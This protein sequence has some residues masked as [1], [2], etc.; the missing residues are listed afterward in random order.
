MKFE[1]PMR[2]SDSRKWKL[3]SFT[4]IIKQYNEFLGINSSVSPIKVSYLES[5]RIALVNLILM[6]DGFHKYYKDKHD[7]KVR[8]E[9]FGWTDAEDRKN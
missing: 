4:D 8:K 6:C 2:I 3:I 7:E 5:E 9:E 1:N